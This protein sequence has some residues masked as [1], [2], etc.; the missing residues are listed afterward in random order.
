[1]RAGWKWS[2]LSVRLAVCT[3]VLLHRVSEGSDLE[4][5]CVGKIGLAKTIE[6]HFGL[7]K[8]CIDYVAH[9]IIIFGTLY[10]YNESGKT[11]KGY[12]M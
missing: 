9:M 11:R 12:A 8:I 10:H 4:R 1:M 2:R 3:H 7:E 5:S 6:E